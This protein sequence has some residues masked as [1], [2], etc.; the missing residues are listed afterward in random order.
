MS[1]LL[2]VLI[3][4]SQ[5]LK[6]DPMEVPSLYSPLPGSVL[7]YS[8]FKNNISKSV[9]FS[10]GLRTS[11]FLSGVLSI[12]S[13]FIKK[14][15]EKVFI[16][17]AFTTQYS[18]VLYSINSHLFL[19][20][21]AGIN[22]SFQDDNPDSLLYDCQNNIYSTLVLMYNR[23]FYNVEL[24]FKYKFINDENYFSGFYFRPD[25][26][27]TYENVLGLNFLSED[28]FLYYKNFKDDTYDVGLRC[29]FDIRNFLYFGV[30]TGVDSKIDST[31]NYTRDKSRYYMYS[32]VSFAYKF[33]NDVLIR[34]EY[35]HAYCSEIDYAHNLKFSAF[36][37]L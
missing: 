12:E 29:I 20:V 2:W 18:K 22:L 23:S 37:V 32:G 5:F 34:L 36:V 27:E 28:A 11:D 13:D 3:F 10:P 24:Y 33:E 30:Y 4:Y 7:I 8:D 21:L 31:H 25:K 1:T 6:A 19:G 35:S 14:N 15:N 17:V 9:L 26:K 16:P